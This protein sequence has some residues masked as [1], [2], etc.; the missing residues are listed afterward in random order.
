MQGP[1]Y[2]KSLFYLRWFDKLPY[3]EIPLLFQEGCPRSGRGG[4]NRTAKRT[5]F[6]WTLLTAPSAL[7]AQTPRLEKAGNVSTLLLPLDELF[8]EVGML[9]LQF[10]ELS[11][12]EELLDLRRMLQGIAIRQHDVRDLSL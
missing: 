4:Y 9:A 6:L 12:D 11:S 5:L 7:S 3:C 10:D 8:V 1:L 2:G